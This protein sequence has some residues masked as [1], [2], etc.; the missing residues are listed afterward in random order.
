MKIFWAAG[1]VLA[2][3]I[4]FAGYKVE[5]TPAVTSAASAASTAVH[6]SVVQLNVQPTDVC[7]GV[8]SNQALS[9][10]LSQLPG[11]VH[12]NSVSNTLFRVAYN[13]QV[14]NLAQLES[15]VLTTTGYQ[16]TS[17]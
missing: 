13:P 1:L 5:A 16:A 3:V 8:L 10:E 4:A 14:T 15:N 9:Q 7:C 11:V 6:T 12:A 17:S 2:S